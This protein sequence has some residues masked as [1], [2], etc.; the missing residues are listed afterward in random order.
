M[1]LPNR[2]PLSDPIPNPSPFDYPRQ[3]IVRGPYWDM[4]V[5]DNLEVGENGELTYPDGTGDGNGSVILQGAWWPMGVGF[6]LTVDQ[7]DKL[8][9]LT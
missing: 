4:L 3:Y 5:S 9:T 1:T 6:G 7:D 2:P 8:S